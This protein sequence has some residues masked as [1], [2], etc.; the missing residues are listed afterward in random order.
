MK[1]IPQTIAALV[2]LSTIV[3]PLMAQ[4]SVE[5]SPPQLSDHPPLLEALTVIGSKEDVYTL[6]GSGYVIDSEEIRSQNYSNVN[7]VLAK[8]PGVYVREE[9][10]FGNF[11]NISLRGADGTRSEKTTIMEDGILSAPATYSAPGAYYSPR[12]GRMHGIDVLKGSSQ[13]NYGPHTTG[14]VINYR[15]TPIPDESTLHGRYTYGSDSTMLAHAY[16]G[17]QVET[18]SGKFGYLFEIFG[19]RSDGFR[20]IQ[21]GQRYAGSDSTGFSVYEPMVKLSWEPNTAV[22]QRLEIKYGYTDLDADESYVHRLTGNGW[23]TWR[24]HPD[25][26]PKEERRRVAWDSMVA[27]FLPDHHTFAYR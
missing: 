14:G 25:G 16:Y 5:P 2:G 18:E 1:A 11:P 3:S 4:D 26:T 9:D 6:P 12:A 15:S 27:P 23:S 20:T 8:V 13:I 19:Q 21:P 24:L 22:P 17:D 7:R 10:G